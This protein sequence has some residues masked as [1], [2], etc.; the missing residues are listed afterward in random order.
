MNY[1]LLKSKMDK[2]FNETSANDLIKKYENLGYTFVPNKLD[3]KNSK[4]KTF[5]HINFMCSELKEHIPW[6]SSKKRSVINQNK[7]L[8][9]FE[10]FLFTLHL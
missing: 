10:V 5:E 7:N 1:E 6:Y 3:Y 4:V 9:I 2:F 8:E